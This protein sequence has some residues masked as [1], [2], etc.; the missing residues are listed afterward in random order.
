MDNIT[1]SREER[2]APGAEGLSRRNVLVTASA[3]AGALAGVQVAWAETPPVGNFGAPLV[4]L[5]VPAGVL[6]LEQRAAMIKGINDVVLG[7][8]KQ[9]PD[10]AKRLFVE[11]I[12]TA[13]GGFGVNGQVF[14][15]RK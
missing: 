4:E 6:S 8:M 10:P 9:P 11:I 5:Y 1:G 3:V 7:A 14:I 12:E 15:P 13:E 2:G